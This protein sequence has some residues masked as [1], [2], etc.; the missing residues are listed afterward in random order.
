MKRDVGIVYV[1][2][3]KIHYNVMELKE[4]LSVDEAEALSKPNNY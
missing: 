4:E 3:R 2:M 1:A